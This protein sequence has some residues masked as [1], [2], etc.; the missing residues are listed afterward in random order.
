MSKFLMM[1]G[2]VTFPLWVPMLI[3]GISEVVSYVTKEKSNG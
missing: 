3:A 1:V 2:F